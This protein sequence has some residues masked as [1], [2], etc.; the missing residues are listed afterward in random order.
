MAGPSLTKDDVAKLLADPSPE[1]RAEAAAKIATDF[2]SGSLSEDERGLAEEIFRLMVKD[3]EVRVREALAINLKESLALPH[4][5]ATV[6]AADVDSVSLPVLEFSEVLTDEDLLEIV[7]TQGSSKLT[8]IAGRASVSENL[9]GALVESGDENVVSTLVSNEGAQ[10]S[11]ASLEH[12]VEKFGDHEKVQTAM[13]ERPKLPVTV[14][15]KLVTRVSEHL[16]DELAKRH[17][18][19]PTTAT[20]LLLQSRERATVSLSTESDEGDVVKLID[21]LHQN[22][23][24][25]SSIILRALCMGDMRFFEAALSKLGE[26]PLV[27]ARSLI[28]DPGALGL[29]RLYEKSELPEQ[30]F[31][32]V[33]AAIDVAQELEYDG[34]SN[35]R[36]RFSRRLI[37]LVLTQY[38]DLGVEFESSDLEYLLT[39]MGNLPPAAMDKD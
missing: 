30:Q 21:Q 12:A 33:R 24:L 25:T 37:E 34:E 2:D 16:K 8:A 6:L 13:V 19:T 15:E 38:D 31:V 39:K 32:A 23:R 14:A 29:K 11:D 17:K 7:S 22:E 20:D 4:D 3:A 10:I 27:N 36:E 9:S 35:D 26:V 18:L 5:V 28:Y 1:S